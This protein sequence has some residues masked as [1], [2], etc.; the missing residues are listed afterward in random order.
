MEFKK[1]DY[2]IDPALSFG[3]TMFTALSTLGL[4]LLFGRKRA[5]NFIELEIE[6]GVK[7]SLDKV[8]PK[9]EWQ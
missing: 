5:K 8:E 4:A 7:G 6:D 9:Y 3:S 1:G 2:S